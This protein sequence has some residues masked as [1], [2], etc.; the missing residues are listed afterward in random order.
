[1]KKLV[2][3]FLIIAMIA[4][5]LLAVIPASADEPEVV[6]LLPAGVLNQLKNEL[7]SSNAGLHAFAPYAP[8]V[9]TNSAVNNK[10]AG[11]K[12]LSINIPVNKT[13]SADANGNFYFTLGVLPSNKAHATASVNDLTKYRIAIKGSEY[14]LN[15]NSNV[16]K[17]I[18]VDLSAY[19]IYVRE[20]ETLTFFDNSD[21]IFP[22]WASTTNSELYVTIR[23]DAPNFMGF[24][25]CAGNIGGSYNASPTACIIFDLE[26]E[27]NIDKAPWREYFIKEMN[28]IIPSFERIEGQF[29]ERGY[30]AKQGE[31][32]D[33]DE[34]RVEI[35]YTHHDGLLANPMNDSSMVFRITGEEK[36]VL[37]L[38]DLGPDGGDI[39]YDESRDKLKSDVVQMAHHGHMNVGMEVYAAIEPKA[40]LWC[41]ADWLYN[42]PEIPHYLENREFLRSVGRGRMY[43][44]TVTRKWM[45]ILGVKEHFVTKDGTNKLFI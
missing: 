40:C 12:L 11:S 21:T 37:F 6:N 2:S 30:I 39:L 14:G 15:A 27:K 7:A 35:L 34:C 45:D 1:M 23:D 5:T 10:I 38:G 16:F 31:V 3:I 32:F 13:G 41:C 24:A 8:Y 42:E 28:S 43:G 9:Y 29:G 25:A 44:T 20:D 33:I 19:N 4:A 36:S 26:L 18:K 22:V 17:F